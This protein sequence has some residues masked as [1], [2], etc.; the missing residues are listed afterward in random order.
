VRSSK[1]SA[2]VVGSFAVATA[3]CSSSTSSPTPVAGGTSQSATTELTVFA[4]SSLTNAFDQIG[5]DFEAATPGTSVT[6]NFGSSTDLAAQIATEG[7]ADVFASASEIAMAA[8]A[9]DPGVVDRVN[10]ASNSLVIITP[11]DDPASV[12]SIGDL[13]T[14]GVQLVLGAAGVPVGDYAREAL[15]RAGISSAALANVVSNEPDDAS[16]VGKIASGEADAAIVYTSDVAGGTNDVRSVTIPADV[17]VRATYSI[18]VI[19]TSAHEAP[20]RAFV[21]YVVGRAGRATLRR[22]GFDTATG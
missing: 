12:S 18:A 1:I 5:T 13:T 10:F 22:F 3:A 6:F 4:A 16:I 14:E 15:E 17:N 9:E 11:P 20:A 19:E 2:V 21:S 8:A 7:T